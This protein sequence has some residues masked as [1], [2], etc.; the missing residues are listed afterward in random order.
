MNLNA[1]NVF[2]SSGSSPI[3]TDIHLISLDDNSVDEFETADQSP[4]YDTDDPHSRHLDYDNS[5][6]HLDYD[7]SPSPIADPYDWTNDDIDDDRALIDTGAMVTCTG[8]KHIIHNFKAYTKLKRCPICL[9]AALSTN[10]SVIPEGYGFLHVRSSG[11]EYRKVLVYY[12]PRI[13][14][15]LLSPTSIIDSSLEPN[16]NFTGQSI[17]RWFDDNTMLTGNVTLVLHHR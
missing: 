7:D 5:P 3:P 1:I 8:T 10:C 13:N 16:G 11:N 17:H 12:H 6:R 14:G 9:K 2:D 15:T 4:V